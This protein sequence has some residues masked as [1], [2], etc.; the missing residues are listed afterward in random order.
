M[1]TTGL[2]SK[3]ELKRV[4]GFGTRERQTAW[5]RQE[6]IPFQLNGKQELVVSWHHVNAWLEGRQVVSSSGPNW[7]ALHA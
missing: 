4:S 5:L 1:P 6:G 7:A 3:P 2:L